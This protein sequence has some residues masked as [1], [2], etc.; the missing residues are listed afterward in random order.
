MDIDLFLLN[1]VN[2][3]KAGSSGGS[4]TSGGYLLKSDGTTSG[5]QNRRPIYSIY[6]NNARYG[7]T[8]QEWSTS[9]GH[10]TLY[11]YGQ[12]ARSRRMLFF[13]AAEYLDSS[14]VSA[15]YNKT[16][17]PKG[18]FYVEGLQGGYGSHHGIRTNS[19]T[20]ASSSS[21]LPFGSRIMFIR[22]PTSSSISTSLEWN[23][24]NHYTSGYDGSSIIQYTPTFSGSA[25]TFS[26]INGVT[27]TRLYQYTSS[28]WSYTTSQ[29]FTVPANTT[30]ALTFNNTMNNW[31]STTSGN[32]IYEINNLGMLHNLPNAGLET[33]LKCTAGYLPLASAQFNQSDNDNNII[34][35]FNMVGEVYG[36]YS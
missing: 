17:G 6:N 23:F 36:E 18:N 35:W 2:K 13:T 31:T 5:A 24:S 8:G 22:N 28:T 3:L 33:C 1:K 27:I 11:V 10:G 9:N 26:T 20:S 7:Y 30:I 16:L 21:Y 15:Y 14:S 4:T 19:M 12:D 25:T 29:N 34:K 32:I